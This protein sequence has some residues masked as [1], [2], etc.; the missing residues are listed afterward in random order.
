MNPFATD[1]NN[2]FLELVY[3]RMYK[4]NRDRSSTDVL[5]NCNSNINNQ[6]INFDVM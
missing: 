2:F 6:H 3:R 4:M 5:I 1:D